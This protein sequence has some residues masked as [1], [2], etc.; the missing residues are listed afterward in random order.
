[1]DGHSGALVMQ[2]M[3]DTN[4]SASNGPPVKR[5][6]KND[7]EP[8]EPRRLR[9]SHEAC[10]R[11]R[12]KKIKCDSKHPRCTACVTAGVACNQEDRHRQ[13]TIAR[14]HTERLEQIVAQ[15]DALLKRHLPGFSLQTI[16][17][18]CARE[19][20]DLSTLQPIQNIPLQTSSVAPP[21]PAYPPPPPPPP[22]VTYY[23][24]QYMYPAPFQVPPIPSSPAAVMIPGQDPNANDM[25]ST[26]ALAKSFGVAPF[27]VNDASASPA[28][29]YYA[30][31]T[32]NNSNSDNPP[33]A[34]PAHLA[35]EDLAVGSSGLDS[36]RDRVVQLEMPAPRDTAKWTVVSVFRSQP[37]SASSS[38]DIWLPTDRNTLLDIV[39][40]YF[41]RL[42]VHRPVFFRHQFLQALNQLYD[43]GASSRPVFDP[44]FICSLYLVLA[45]GTLSEL[46]RSGYPGEVPA[47]DGDVSMDDEGSKE[48][49]DS[50]SPRL[51]SKGRMAAKATTA[52]NSRLPPDWPAHDE[53]FDRALAVKPELRVTLS[54][55]QALILLQ[56]YL[57][58]ERQG[59]TLWRLVGSIVRLAIEL[60]LHHDPTTQTMPDP[61]PSEESDKKEIPTF[62]PLESILR[63]RLWSIVLVHDRGTSILLGRPLA[64]S[65][66]DANTPRP[67]RP[68]I[69][70]PAFTVPPAQ[71]DLD[72]SEHFLVSAPIADIQAD[73]IM[74]LYSPTRQ[75]GETLLRNASRIIES[76]KNFRRSLPASYKNYF[77]GT[78]HWSLSRR[79]DLL[80]TLSESAGLT[81]LKLAISRILL[82]RALFSS[83]ELGYPERRKALVDAMIQ[84]HNVIAI[85]TVLV[86][87]PEMSRCDKEIPGLSDGEGGEQDGA[88]NAVR[89]LMEDVW[90]ALDMLPRF[91]W[92]WETGSGAS[93]GTN[94]LIAKLAEIVMESSYSEAGLRGVGAPDE[95]DKRAERGEIRESRLISGIGRQGPVGQPVL[96]P[97]PEWEEEST[98]PN[99]EKPTSTTPIATNG[100]SWVDD[101]G[102]PSSQQST[103]TLQP[104]YPPTSYP[105]S[106][107]ASS[108][109]STVSSSTY[110]YP[111][112][113]A[114]VTNAGGIS[115]PHAQYPAF[116]PPVFGP[117]PA[118]G[119]NEVPPSKNAVP[120]SSTTN[121][122][123]PVTP[124]RTTAAMPA[125]SIP[126]HMVEVP[127][128]LFY[129][130]YQ[131]TEGMAPSSDNTSHAHSNGLLSPPPP[132]PRVTRTAA[133]GVPN[134]QLGCSAGACTWRT[135][136]RAGYVHNRRKA[137]FPSTPSSTRPSTATN[138]SATP[139]VPYSSRPVNGAYA[140]HGGHPMPP[141]HGW[142]A[143][144]G[145]TSTSR[146]NGYAVQPSS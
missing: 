102:S 90:L 58:A 54:S 66:R 96:I 81:L 52:S 62:T 41:S 25:S 117:Q 74:S 42:N 145:H 5:R 59:R 12:G 71:T 91:R 141:T 106:S 99:R 4:A 37:F 43:E 50:A 55:L 98:S 126:M 17:D 143:H 139:S 69:G 23:Q 8:S 36:G 26:H 85:H 2:T 110:T 86:R 129:P 114:S 32:V 87:F 84:A 1:M 68:R 125:S 118:N 9:R 20:I 137:I 104:A 10:T 45:L 70:D 72:M 47:A 24:Y 130:F 44:G 35:E 131:P 115:Y 82:L 112:P 49:Q 138:L 40:V 46:N 93:A 13:T 56:W 109:S 21:Q 15:C 95:S 31:P 92:R 67:S 140:I 121:G 103:P 127:Q 113:P 16:D 116:G 142:V 38:M 146:A 27:I 133:S 3:D 89:I 94:P 88:G 75:S 18:L 101:T 51:R 111:P 124:I 30:P 78:A 34:A 105:R 28:P 122:S 6:R 123:A 97:E 48:E 39:D 132:P 108:R 107:T 128:S 22:G 19:G 65:P 33:S 76:I 83:K 60:G 79:H 135:T 64:I 136:G 61:N 14:D 100:P 80:S 11:C 119:S 120:I 53:F 63:I 77:T 7:G 144:N 134:G 29:V 73:I 57:Y